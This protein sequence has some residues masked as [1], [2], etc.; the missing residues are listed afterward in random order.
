ML[1][2]D[3][4]TRSMYKKA[5]QKLGVLNRISLLLVP[6]K[7][8]LVVNAV[9]KSHF[10]YCPSIWIFNSRRSINLKSE[11]RKVSKNNL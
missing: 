10:I 1:Q 8:K 4:H 11:S 3:P 6:E 9:L 5:V 7:E 2:F